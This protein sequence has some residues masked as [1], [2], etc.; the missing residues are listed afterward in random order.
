M[1]KNITKYWCTFTFS[2]HLPLNVAQWTV[3][4]HEVH[5]QKRVHTAQ[6]K[7]KAEFWIAQ[8]LLFKFLSGCSTWD[9]WNVT[10]SETKC[11]TNPLFKCL[12]ELKSFTESNLFIL[13]SCMT[14][15]HD[16]LLYYTL[17]FHFLFVSPSTAFKQSKNPRGKK[18][19]LVSF[20]CRLSIPDLNLFSL[21]RKTNFNQKLQKHIAFDVF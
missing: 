3:C 2:P 5:K 21:P 16:S 6:D 13:F 11:E 19:Q 9:I 10:F 4:A 7:D 8:V 14:V 18:Q 12:K 1:K 15:F 20:S 17:W